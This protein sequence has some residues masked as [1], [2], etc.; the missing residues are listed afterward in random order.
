MIPLQVVYKLY[1][2]QY[3]HN[4]YTVYIIYIIHSL[5]S[6][7]YGPQIKLKHSACETDD[8]LRASIASRQ[9]RTCAKLLVRLL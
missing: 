3:M 7:G 8:A 1:Y 5:A 6:Y 2:M 4:I 9:R